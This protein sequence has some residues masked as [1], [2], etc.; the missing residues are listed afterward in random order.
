MTDLVIING[1]GNRILWDSDGDGKAPGPEQYKNFD[2]FVSQ[3]REQKVVAPGTHRTGSHQGTVYQT[4]QLPPENKT[5]YVPLGEGQSFWT[6]AEDLGMD[7]D[8]NPEKWMQLV[9]DN[10]QYTNPDQIPDGEV[11]AVNVDLLP[12][13]VRAKLAPSPQGTADAYGQHLSPLTKGSIPSDAQNSIMNGAAEGL[14]AG[15]SPMTP[16]QRVETVEKILA[17]P[18]IPEEGKKRAVAVY[19]G[20]VSPEQRDDAMFGIL[21]NPNISKE[22]KAKAVEA[23]LEGFPEGERAKAAEQLNVG[24]Y[25]DG[26]QLAF[27]Y[28]EIIRMAVTH[29]KIE[30]VDLGK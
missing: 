8:A 18:A 9:A 11:I 28:R 5:I 7:P 10:P 22:N 30:N 29:L 23:Y 24:G 1:Q 21:D 4:G 16:E 6:L 13:D 15:L 20:L 2:Q 26:S 27:P 19:L 3:F 12:P 17:D 25:Y 14:E